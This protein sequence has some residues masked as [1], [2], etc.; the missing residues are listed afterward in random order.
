V[1]YPDWRLEEDHA[2]FNA[3][4]DWPS[5]LTKYPTDIVLVPNRLNVAKELSGVANWRLVYRD[6][7]FAMFARD[8][9]A[10]PMSETDADP[11]DGTF[12]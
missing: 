4:E 1:A 10:L 3:R 9:L 11:P 12:P 2:F 7:Q 5:V 8:K 6:S